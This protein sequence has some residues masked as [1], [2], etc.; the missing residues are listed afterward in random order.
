MTDRDLMADAAPP[1]TRAQ[2]LLDQYVIALS[3][4]MLA[5]GLRQWAVILGPCTPFSSARSVP[6]FLSWRSTW[7]RWPFSL[8]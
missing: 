3:V 5:F 8:R 4:V 2:T 7:S 1:R 6:I